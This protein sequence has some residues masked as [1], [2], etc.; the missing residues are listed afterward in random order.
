[1]EKNGNPASW[2]SSIGRLLTFPC[3]IL[4][5]SF[6]IGYDA[7]P[8]S[9]VTRVRTQDDWT[10]DLWREDRIELFLDPGF[11]RQIYLQ[12][13]LNSLGLGTDGRWI[14]SRP[15]STW[16]ANGKATAI[17]D[18]DRWTAEYAFFFDRAEQSSPSPGAIWR[19]SPWMGIT[20]EKYSCRW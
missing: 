8:D 3:C 12:I 1:M 13:S 10:A 6:P 19:L 14:G 11:S 15:E 4:C 17:V 18:D 5:L 2:L 7:H 20:S 9:L 16:N